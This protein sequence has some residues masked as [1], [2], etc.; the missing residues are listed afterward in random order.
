M[1]IE[2]LLIESH[3]LEEGPGWDQAKQGLGQVAQGVGNVAKGAVTGIPGAVG[4]AAKG[5]GAVAGGLR[6][7]WDKAK[8]GYNAGRAAVGGNAVPGA[9]QQAGGQQ[10]AG[11]PAQGGGQDPNQLRQ[12]GKALI[13][14]ADDLEKQ[15]SQQQGQQQQGGD[16]QA[17]ASGAPTGSQSNAE[18][19][20]NA[21][22]AQ[23]QQPPADQAGNSAFGNMAANLGGAQDP[24]APTTSSTG[25]TTTPTPTGQVHTANP[26]N[27]NN[28]QGQTPPPADA[29]AQTSPAQTAPANA[30]A[31]NP[32]AGQTPPAQTPP[33]TTAPSKQDK[34]AM[35]NQYK[36]DVNTANIAAQKPGFQ[37]D[38]TD[39][40]AMKK[41]NNT[42]AGPKINAYGKQ[43]EGFESRFLGMTI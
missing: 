36:A 28:P 31:T 42:G 39:N 32:P 16:Q 26:N 37:R 12:Q 20:A 4:G 8:Q 27:P 1:R 34:K 7:A 6:G 9:Q 18:G 25:G 29:N 13:K 23:G 5:V 10:A 33:A 21:A 14:Q 40:L 2:E 38:A 19:G 11:A 17:D 15:Q 43:Y 41:V 35:K 30:T 22:P 3:N 24:N